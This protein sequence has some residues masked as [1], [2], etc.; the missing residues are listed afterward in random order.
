MKLKLA[1]TE[2]EEGQMI[3]LSFSSPLC[4]HIFVDVNS[5]TLFIEE[6]VC[7]LHVGVCKQAYC[8]IVRWFLLKTNVEPFVV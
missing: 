3:A 6:N 5:V 4:L 7:R 8:I 2:S 1:C